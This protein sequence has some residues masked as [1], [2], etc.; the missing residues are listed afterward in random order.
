[1]TTFPLPRTVT[2]AEVAARLRTE[3]HV[4]V[5]T[6][7]SPD[8]DALGS[9]SAFTLVARGLGVEVTGYVPGGAALPEEYAFLQGLEDLRRGDPPLVDEGTTVYMLDCA[10]LLRSHGDRFEAGAFRVNIDHHQDNPGYGELNLIVPD[11]ASTTAI[12]YDIFRAGGMT[13][14]IH[15]ATALY[16]GL[17]TDTGRFQYSNTT[18]AAH[19]MAA[20]L[21]EGGLDVNQVY[22]RVYESTPLPKL[23]LLQEALCHLE[24]RLGGGLVLAWVDRESFVRAGAED[25]HTEGI[26]DQLR[27]IQGVRVAAFLRERRTD[28]SPEYKVSL[29]STDGRVDVAAI[30]NLRGGGGHVRAAGFTFTGSVEDAMDWIEDQVRERL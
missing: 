4:L 20:D 26:V 27:R 14:D 5:V 21:L 22:R 28:G 25:G 2:P 6:H 23:L 29:R 10:S 18:P 30:A 24:M 12:L 19:R 17:V 13:I 15:V 3:R 11:A 9:L 16:V 1:M 7:E 8:G